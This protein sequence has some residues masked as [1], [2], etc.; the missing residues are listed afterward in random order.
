MSLFIFFLL[1]TQLEAR[2]SAFKFSNAGLAQY[3][4]FRKDFAGEWCEFKSE[5]EK[6]ASQP[7]AKRNMRFLRI[8]T[9]VMF[10]VLSNV[11]FV[12]WKI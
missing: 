3:R 5:K 10:S 1:F 2:S 7:S 11:G 6:G 12:L 4:Q 8:T 9:E